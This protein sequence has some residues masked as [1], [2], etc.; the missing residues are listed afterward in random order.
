[1][2]NNV[3]KRLMQYLKKYRI[4]LF[5][6]FFFS[7]VSTIFTVLA[8]SVMG[9]ITNALYDGVATGV[10]DVER[11]VILILALILLY[12][13]GQLFAF[14]QNFGMAKITAKVMQSLRRDIDRKMH[15][16]KLD[17]YDTRTNGEIL[18]VIT[19]DVDTVNNAISQ[20]LT[21]IVTQVITVCLSIKKSCK[22]A[23][24]K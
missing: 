6:V 15:S 7:V 14:F 19:N 23:P 12:L 11:I 17:Y 3:I 22:R 21:Q 4:S 9:G 8:P 1:M 5:F 13:V 10:F 16:M 24:K 2:K 20:N 18:S